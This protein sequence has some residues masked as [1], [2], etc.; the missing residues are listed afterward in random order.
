MS[1]VPAKVAAGLFGSRNAP[2][3]GDRRSVMSA[4]LHN[5]RDHQ[6]RIGR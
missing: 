4:L 1:D 3:S 2:M 5:G 6:Q